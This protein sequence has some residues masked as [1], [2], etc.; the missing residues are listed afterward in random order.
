A[1]GRAGPGVRSGNEP[2]VPARIGLRSEARTCRLPIKN[3]AKPNVQTG[4]RVR[5]ARCGQPADGCFRRPRPVPLPAA[6]EAA[7]LA[8]RAGAP[9]AFFAVASVLARAPEP[10][11]LRAVVDF[12]PELAL[13]APRPPPSCS[14]TSRTAR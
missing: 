8:A 5:R 13:R 1:R 6:A 10:P 7:G 12:P 14:A 2:A 3:C 9:P 4:R 11:A